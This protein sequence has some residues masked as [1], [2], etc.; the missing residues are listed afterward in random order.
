VS[1]PSEFHHQLLVCEEG[2]QLS[3]VDVCG[4]GGFAETGYAFLAALQKRQTRGG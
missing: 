4:E 3:I 1:P 2:D